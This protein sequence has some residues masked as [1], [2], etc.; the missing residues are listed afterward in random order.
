[1]EQLFSGKTQKVIYNFNRLTLYKK[2][3]TVVNYKAVIRYSTDRPCSHDGVSAETIEAI[4]LQE[5]YS[6]NVQH[7]V[8]GVYNELGRLIEQL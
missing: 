4:W 6:G 8:N 3:C 7:E 5:V 1:M 2:L